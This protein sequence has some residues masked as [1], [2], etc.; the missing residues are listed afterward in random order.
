[1]RAEKQEKRGREMKEGSEKGHK[2][3]IN[4][5]ELRNWAKEVEKGERAEKQDKVGDR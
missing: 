4:E 1:M 3:Q 5:R 2:R